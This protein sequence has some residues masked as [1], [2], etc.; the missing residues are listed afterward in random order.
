MGQTRNILFYIRH[1]FCGFGGC[2]MT[3]QIQGMNQLL[4]KKAWW[5]L[6]HQGQVISHL[7]NMNFSS[8][9]S[10]TSGTIQKLKKILK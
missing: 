3:L 6:S 1:V 8:G 5:E 2:K 4:F 9:V 10:Y 7:R